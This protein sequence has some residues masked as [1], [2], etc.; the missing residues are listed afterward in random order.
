MYASWPKN[1]LGKL[2]HT[3]V[4]YALHWLFVQRH[5][6]YVKG[7]PWMEEGRLAIVFRGVL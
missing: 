5:G 7:P 6:W 4:R 3:T 2:G 1:E